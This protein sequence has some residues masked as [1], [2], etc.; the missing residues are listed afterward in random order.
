MD[1]L[2]ILDAIKR[3]EIPAMT[4]GR[5]LADPDQVWARSQVYPNTA[6]SAS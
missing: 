5:G 6:A 2:T 4:T 3:G 1:R